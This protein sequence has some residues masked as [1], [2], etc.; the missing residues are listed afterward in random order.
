MSFLYQSSGRVTKRNC[1]FPFCIKRRRRVD[2]SIF[3]AFSA[4]M[5]MESRGMRRAF[6]TWRTVKVASSIS[7]LSVALSPSPSKI[8]SSP[9]RLLIPFS[10]KSF[11]AFSRKITRR[12]RQLSSAPN[13]IPMSMDRISSLSINFKKISFLSKRR[14]KI[15]P[16]FHSRSMSSPMSANNRNHESSTMRENQSVAP[17]LNSSASISS[18]GMS[19]YSKSS[20][21]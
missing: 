11:L 3:F 10:T 14:S 18:M 16:R 15:L 1:I 6:A 2:A 7:L 4:D 20:S 19:I 8:C 21:A 5:E 17:R 9:K 12:E 13:L